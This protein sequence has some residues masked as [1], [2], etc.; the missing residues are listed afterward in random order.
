MAIMTV[1]ARFQPLFSSG[2]N[3][4]RFGFV[5]I[6]TKPVGVQPAMGGLETVVDNTECLVS[7]ESDVQLSVIGHGERF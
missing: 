6:Q 2:T 5:W 1:R 7:A 3:D 4:D